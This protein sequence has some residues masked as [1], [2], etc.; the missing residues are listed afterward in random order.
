MKE[1]V[2]YIGI[3]CI[4]AIV[5]ISAQRLIGTIMVRDKKYKVPVIIVLSIML[6]IAILFTC[7]IGE[8][9]KIY[10]YRY[11]DELLDTYEM[12]DDT[13]LDTKET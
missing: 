1:Y 2:C 7:Y 6:L 3:I 5:V 12:V 9:A 4:L 13:E 11:I 8:K 10:G